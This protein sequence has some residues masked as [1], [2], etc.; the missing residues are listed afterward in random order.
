MNRLVFVAA[1][2][3]ALLTPLLTPLTGRSEATGTTQAE[4][5]I[6]PVALASVLIQDK[7]YDR[8]RTLLSTVNPKTLKTDRDRFHMLYGLTLLELADY[9]AADQ[10]LTQSIAA[11]QKDPLV[12]LFLAQ[13]RFS[14]EDFPGAVEA[15]EQAGDKGKTSVGAF[16]LHAQS[17]WRSDEKNRAYEVLSE[18]I[19]AFPDD[20]SLKKN[21]VMLLVDLGLY[22]AAVNEGY[23]YLKDV[24]SDVKETIAFSQALISAKQYDEAIRLLESA[25]LVHPEEVNVAIQLAQAYLAQGHTFTAA[26]L[27]EHAARTDA[28]LLLDA[29][30]LY[31]RA[32]RLDTAER[33]NAKVADQKTKIRQRLGLLIELS[34]FEEAAALGPRLDRLGLLK[35][36]AVTYGLAY[37]YFMTGQFDAAERRLK[38][39]SDAALFEKAIQLRRIMGTCAASGWQCP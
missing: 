3:L 13:A 5:E 11:G 25:R 12:Y 30:E 18:G 35:E 26:R 2:S 19:A 34:R 14:L 6:D 36:D 29:A 23:A 17:L 37:A 9:K 16:L 38:T 15:M 39:I 31:R 4:E 33:L 32:N 24:K 20:T 21:R 1:V 28:A 7:H 27:F 10:Q 22:Q 8:A